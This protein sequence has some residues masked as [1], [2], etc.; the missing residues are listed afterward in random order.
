MKL[1]VG[2]GNPG[3]EYENTRHNVGFMILDSF[4]N[5]FS[6]EKKFQ[7]ML[8]KM[9]ISGE[10]VLFVKP[11]TFMNLS[12]NA[13]GK[14]VSYYH[15][16]REDIMIIQDDLD[17]A[18]GRLRIKTNSSAGGHNGIKSIISS[19]GTQEFCR[20]KVGIAH[21]KD[22]ST[23]DYVLQKFSKEEMKF[24]EENYSY[25][26]EIIHSFIINGIDKTMALYNHNKEI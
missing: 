5:D 25:F 15:I 1:V 19:L 23:V 13:V 6:F 20:F 16:L 2:L 12:G 21:N 26:Q 14:I 9:K 17:L 10:E 3:R 24:F 18:F 22:I 11:L 8:S 7:A 4:I